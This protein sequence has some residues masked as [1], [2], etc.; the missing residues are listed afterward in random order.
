MVNIIYLIITIWAL[1][2]FYL[3]LVSRNQISILFQTNSETRAFTN[4]NKV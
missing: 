1:L 2:L 4:K 3:K